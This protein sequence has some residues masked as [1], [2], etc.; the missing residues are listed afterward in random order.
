MKKIESKKQ[1]KRKTDITDVIQ[2]DEGDSIRETHSRVSSTKTPSYYVNDKGGMDYVDEGYMRLMLNEAYPIWSWEVQKYEFIGD[3]AIAVHGR[4]TI[5]DSGIVRH[6]E[7]CAA[8]RV[9]ISKKTGDYIDLGNDLKSAVTDC[10]KVCVNR[11]T[12]IADDIYRKQYLN[13]KQIL[14]IEHKLAEVEDAGIR[15]KVVRGIKAKTITAVNLE[16]TLTKLTEI[17]KKQNKANKGEE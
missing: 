15:G 3:K 11:L 5:V 10:F 14:S 12:N 6:F 8:H 16:G 17:I 13:S 2:V 9:A 7:S 4:L 1:L